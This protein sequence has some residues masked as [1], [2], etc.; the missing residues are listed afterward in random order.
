[1]IGIIDLRRLGGRELVG[2]CGFKFETIIS[3][4]TRQAHLSGLHPDV[5]EVRHPRRFSNHAE[6]VDIAVSDLAPVLECDAKLEGRFRGAH[7]G[8]LVHAEQMVK[9][10]VRWNCRFTNAHG[11]D[12]V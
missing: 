6:R 12:L 2:L 9:D 11:P 5:V 10:A 7:E 1:M 3:K 8:P 4:V